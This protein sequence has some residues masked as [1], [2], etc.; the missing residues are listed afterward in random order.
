MNIKKPTK[1]PQHPI[2]TK[3]HNKNKLEDELQHFKSQLNNHLDFE[4]MIGDISHNFSQLPANKIDTGLKNALAIIGKYFAFD[5]ATL[6]VFS[7][8]KPALVNVSSWNKKGT[9]LFIKEAQEIWPEKLPWLN[10]KINKKEIVYIQNL[11]KISFKST[12]EKKF[13]KK[14]K[15]KTLIIIPLILKNKCI[16]I[17]N[18][19]SVTAEKVFPGIEI[20]SLHIISDMMINSLQK[21]QTE[22][23]KLE[24]S[25]SLKNALLNII[26]S[27]SLS[28]EKRDPYT[29]GHQQRVAQLAECIAHEMKLDKKNIE[30]IKLGALIHDIGKNC[31]P[32][33][34]LNRPGKLSVNEFNLIKTHPISGYEIVKNVNFPW[35]IAEIILKHHERL[36]GTGYPSGLM[37]DDI[38]LEARIIAVADVVEAICSQR[39]YRAALTLNDAIKELKKHGGKAY[40]KKVVHAFLQLVKKDK[41]PFACTKK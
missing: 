29:S 17:I 15:I 25:Q 35:P 2:Y 30:G 3:T 14:S 20:K 4:K 7:A 13:W 31:V 5:H 36:D 8:S 6:L 19:D 37:K 23:I 34:I 38:N 12:D 11:Q 22:I 18:L 28:L 21:K 9:T 16:G 24:Q 26:S 40:D 32:S 10:D 1:K 39:P 27:L 41:L 33:D